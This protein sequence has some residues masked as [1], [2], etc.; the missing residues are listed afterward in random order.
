MYKWLK[1]AGAGGDGAMS[2]E[3]SLALHK[4][5]FAFLIVVALVATIALRFVAPEQPERLV[6]P[7]LMVLLAS[8]GGYFLLRGNIQA[9]IKVFSYGAW[10]GVTVISFFTNGVDAPAIIAYPLII[11]MTGWM[12]GALAAAFVA[13][14][15][16]V[17]TAGFVWAESAGF[18]PV[19]SASSPALRGGDQIV[20]YLLS[21]ALIVFLVNAY[22]NR[23]A[24]IRIAGRKLDARTKDLEM[25]TTELHQAQAVAK[26]G[27]W[28]FDPAADAITLTAEACRIFGLP[29]GTPEIHGAFPA[30]VHPGDRDALGRAWQALARG[31]VFELEHRIVDGA[32]VRWCRSKAQLEFDLDGRPLRSVGTTQDI[33]QSK[34]TEDS[35]RKSVA[36]ADSLSEAMPLP[37][38]HKDAS[39]RYTGCNAAF[40]RFIGKARHE[41]IGKSVGE[42]AQKVFATTYRDKD[43]DL[44]NGPS[45][46][47][48]YESSVA[49]ADGT[50]HDVIFHKARLTGS[51]GIPVGIVGVITDITELKQI[52]AKQVDLEA[53]LRESQK[54][55]AL[56]TLAGGV[57]HDFNNIVAAI[58][59][60]A[61][62]ARQDVGP[63]HPAS[64]SLE[65]IRKAG[66]RAKDLV[67]Q[68]LA[69][70][71]RQGLARKVIS[72]APVV[73]ESARLL[74]TT[75]LGAV[76]L[77][78]ECCA[79]APAVL[80]DS[81]QIQ[82]VLLNLCGNAR[83]AVQDQGRAGAI[84]VR[85]D[86]Q[87]R[88]GLRFASLK[89]SD[90]GCGMDE[91]TRNRIFEPFF[92]TKPVGKG[93]GLGLAVVHSILKDHEASIEVSSAPGAGTTFAIYFP[94]AQASAQ[95]ASV[96]APSAT[97]ARGRGRHVLYVD[98]DEAIV[99]LMTRLLERQ[100][101]RVSGYTDAQQALDAVRA[102]PGEFDL[103]VTDHNMPG[104]S[105]L[106]VAYA[107]KQIRADLPVA[108]ASGYITDELRLSAPAA[109]IRELIYK[110]NT[111][112]DLCVAV[113]RLMQAVG[114]RPEPSRSGR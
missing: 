13:G 104:M 78:I 105:G 80:A 35:L 26:I 5:V 81:T 85:L 112:E 27:S 108:M 114:E 23:L 99:F 107:L 89:V 57:A 3:H 72:L 113:A 44:I 110:P 32:T 70:G 54:M 18:L 87:V 76:T 86:A 9:T 79:D 7:L 47:Q 53:Q 52:H 28:V 21:A 12:I 61:E 73:D 63:A 92:T 1:D 45:G 2:T 6:G 75:M 60:N 40:E 96:R 24:E 4:Y 15:T 66:N 83:H 42:V 91:A 97:P 37:V 41:I 39:G 100:G 101:Y 93:T 30:S 36:F 82:Q 31:E 14:L 16:V 55:E 33:T 62:L 22:N 56:G 111:V 34:A 106:E 102:N 103:V 11:L 50:V 8:T 98:D 51:A 17:T 67:Q 10:A 25:R 88:N 109:G 38:F 74:R 29:P 46:T 95:I 68:I 43:L 48:T 58:I 90:N 84:A 19:P 71:R 59:G 64:E 94:A 20:I 69:F 77:S 65:E 49:H